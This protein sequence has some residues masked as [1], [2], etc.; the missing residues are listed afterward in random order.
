MPRHGSGRHA[1]VDH[2]PHKVARL[3]IL[4][5]NSDLRKLWEP[6][7]HESRVK[8]KN[9]DEILAK[10]TLVN[11]LFVP[12]SGRHRDTEFFN[13]IC[14]KRTCQDLLHAFSARPPPDGSWGRQFELLRHQ[15]AMHSP[16]AHDRAAVQRTASRWHYVCVLAAVPPNLLMLG[17]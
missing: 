13:R 7:L 14:T 3:Q 16:Y 10:R 4:V 12:R 6:N 9:P 5:K 1:D 15:W 17:L 8:R 2:A 11:G